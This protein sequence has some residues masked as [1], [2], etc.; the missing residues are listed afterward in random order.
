MMTLDDVYGSEFDKFPLEQDALNW[1]EN[2][3]LVW[4][5]PE[6]RRLTIEYDTDHR[7]TQH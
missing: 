1:D 6:V 4:D 3:G 7:F 5:E 2:D